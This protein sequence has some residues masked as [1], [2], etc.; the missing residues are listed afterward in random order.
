MCIVYNNTSTH[1]LTSNVKWFRYLVSRDTIF[2]FSQL[3]RWLLFALREVTMPARMQHMHDAQC[4][5]CFCLHLIDLIW[6]WRS[7]VWKI[8]WKHPKNSIQSKKKK[9]SKRKK[10]PGFNN[11]QSA[12]LRLTVS[13]SCY[14]LSLSPTSPL[15]SS[16]AAYAFFKMC[17]RLKV[18]LL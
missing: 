6:L 10:I 15:S 12:I 14:S 2:P 5:L 18:G 7:Q 3:K 11:Q 9:K 8:H 1:K 13:L 17:K 4:D 16:T